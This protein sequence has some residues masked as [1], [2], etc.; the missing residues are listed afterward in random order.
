MIMALIL[1][2]IS[3]ASCLDTVFCEISET[4]IETG[5]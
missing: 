3:V 5:S 1:K 2:E 4:D